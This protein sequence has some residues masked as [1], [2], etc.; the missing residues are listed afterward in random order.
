MADPGRFRYGETPS[1]RRS[2]PLYNPARAS[3]PVTSVG[4][5]SLYAGDVNVVPAHHLDPHDHRDHEPLTRSAEFR[6]DPLPAASTYSTRKD[7][8]GRSTSARE[9]GGGRGSRYSTAESSSRRPIIV[10]TKHTP[11]HASSATRS[12][13]PSRDPYR[14]SDEGQYYAQPASSIPRGRGSQAGFSSTMDNDEYLRLK[15]RTEHDR[16]VDPRAEPPVRS[17]RPTV[18]YTS[19]NGHRSAARE[20]EDEGFEYTKPSDLARYDLDQSKPPRRSRRESLDRYYRPT[21]SVTTDANARPY[22]QNE[23]RTRGPPPTTWGLDKVNARIPAGGIYDGATVPGGIRMPAIPPAVPL[24]PGLTR[25]PPS[26]N[27]ASPERRSVSRTR[28]ISLIQDPERPA[29]HE[30]YYRPREDDIAPRETRDRDFFQD[31]S[32]SSRGFGIRVDPADLDDR[33]RRP[34]VDVRDER[35]DRLEPRR[36]HPD[37]DLRKRTSYDDLDIPGRS[38][39]PR[40]RHVRD[41]E[42][43]RD[44]DR[45]YERDHHRDH[46]QRDHDQ[47]DHREFRDPRDHPDRSQARW[48]EEDLARDRRDPKGKE[49]AA[50][51]EVESRRERLGSKVATGLGVAAASV[52]PSILKKKEKPVVDEDDAKSSRRR[53]AEQEEEE[54]LSR[55]RRD[56]RVEVEDDISR[57]RRDDRVEDDIPVVSRRRRDEDIDNRRPRDERVEDDVPVVSRRH[58]DEE[59]DSRRPVDDGRRPADDGRRPGDDGRRPV[60]DT[61]RPVDDRY[62]PTEDARPRPVR[63]EDLLGDEDFEIVEHPKDRV[64]HDDISVATTDARDSGDVGGEAVKVSRRDPSSSTDDGKPA[65]STRRRNRASSAFDP[66]DAAGLAAIKAQIVAQEEKEKADRRVPTIREPSPERRDQREPPEPSHDDVSDLSDKGDSR[67]RELIIPDRDE[68]QVRVVSPPRDKDDKK[69]IKS[70]LKQPK[71][72]FPEEKNPVR[73]GVAP[74]KDD[75]TKANVPPGAKWTKINR[76]MVNPEALI[77]GKERFEIRDDHVVVLRV[78]NKEEIQAYALATAQLRGGLHISSLSCGSSCF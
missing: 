62:R 43:D 33:R 56:E 15:E 54:E 58:R 76:K 57:R 18:L 49:P 6:R 65:P 44:Y 35:R 5:N 7:P 23:R 41:R 39:E 71:P 1:T 24:A 9:D 36:E 72:Q 13:S 63:K 60:D 14:S 50:E 47:R 26:E 34:E 25:R 52:L 66:N 55:R 20:Y 27:P 48:V 16:L 38:Y 10:T 69:P 70:I 19:T 67:G 78:L 75:K 8:L 45:D 2:P 46:D 17:T 21:V 64:Q 3:M 32:V 42:R 74:H 11:S 73:E 28:P 37:Q 30:A 53:R 59:P 77:I 61:R 31:N 22:E 40:D 68:K 4:Y 12:G 51:E 29:H